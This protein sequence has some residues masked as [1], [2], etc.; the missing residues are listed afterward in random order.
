[1]S[2]TN[3][4]RIFSYILSEKYYISIKLQ[5]L[6]IFENFKMWSNCTNC[7]QCNQNSNQNLIQ[8]SRLTRFEIYWFADLSLKNR[9]CRNFILFNGAILFLIT[10]YL[11]IVHLLFKVCFKSSFFRVRHVIKWLNINIDLEMYR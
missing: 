2:C 11:L 9:K 7:K 1:M 8:F 10:K 6:I 4:A 3:F 5:S